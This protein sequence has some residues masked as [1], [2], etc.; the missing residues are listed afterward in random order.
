MIKRIK[1]ILIVCLLI[2]AKLVCIAFADFSGQVVGVIDGDTLDIMYDGKAVRIRL[3]GI[4]CPE[5]G[6]AFGQRAKQYA[7]DLAFG[8]TVTVREVGTGGFGRTSGKIILSDGRILNC[9]LV[10]AG[11]AWWA[12]QYAPNDK[13]LEA[14]ENEARVAKVGLWADADP[15]APRQWRKDG[16]KNSN[17]GKQ[18]AISYYQS[19]HE[20]A[21]NGD[22]AAIQRYLQ[23]HGGSVHVKNSQNETL[24]MWAAAQGQLDMVKF[25]VDRGADFHARTKADKT[26][27][28]G[29][30]VVDGYTALFFAANNGHLEVVKY[31]VDKGADPNAINVED[32]A[33]PKKLAWIGGHMDIVEFFRSRSP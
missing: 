31:L 4:D 20:A 33:T 28:G 24:L 23:Q 15:V 16:K 32:G 12:R 25:L 18:N 26:L 2:F 29:K 5:K 21:G 11:L 19:I 10:R 6:Q 14:L 17:E 1:L 8:K 27:P 22:I 9:E 7:S 3:S 30:V 13:E